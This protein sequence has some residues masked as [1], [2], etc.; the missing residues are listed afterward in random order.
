M[1]FNSCRSCR[2]RTVSCYK[3]KSLTEILLE[4]QGPAAQAIDNRRDTSEIT[5]S[6]VMDYA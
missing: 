1:D 5:I 4:R 6:E 2:T 3:G